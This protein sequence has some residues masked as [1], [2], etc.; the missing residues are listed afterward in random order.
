MDVLNLGLYV[1]MTLLSKI[2][3]TKPSYGGDSDKT[4]GDVAEPDIRSLTIGAGTSLRPL[5]LVDFA[6]RGTGSTTDS[7]DLVF[8]CY[9]VR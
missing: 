8:G 1:L 7:K 3:K 5:F 4:I 2:S 6:Y 9:N